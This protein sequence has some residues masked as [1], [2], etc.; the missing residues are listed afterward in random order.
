MKKTHGFI[1]GIWL[2]VFF[3]FCNALP[4]Q[5]YEI[6]NYNSIPG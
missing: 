1:K 4:G 6:R 2:F 3:W 5:T